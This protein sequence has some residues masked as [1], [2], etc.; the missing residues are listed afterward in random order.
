MTDKGVLRV[1]TTINNPRDF[2]VFRRPEGTDA[3]HAPGWMKLRKGVADIHRRAQVS[4]AA[5]ERYLAALAA[6]GTPEPLRRVIEQVCRPT[7]WKGARV[8]A[9]RP[10]HAEEMALL[11][12]VSRGEYSING[13]RNRDICHA[14]FPASSSEKAKRQQS[15]VVTRK[16]RLLRA[17]G[18]ISKVPRTYRYVL[19]TKGRQVVS[20]LLAAQEANVEELQKLAA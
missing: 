1:E 15:A 19:T 10:F 6:A 12:Q 5:N 7:H 3:S 11:E 8:R 20:A 17:H 9:L 4:D 16:L 13:V 18:L 2:K 14:L